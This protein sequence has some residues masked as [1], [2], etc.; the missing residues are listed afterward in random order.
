MTETHVIRI[1]NLEAT[2]TTPDGFAA[3]LTAALCARHGYSSTIVDP[4]TDTESPNPQTQEQFAADVVLKF[5]RDEVRAH[6]AQLA[7]QTAGAAA[8]AQMDAFRD[9]LAVSTTD[10]S[11]GEVP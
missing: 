11:E 7:E 3:M 10:L 4:D 5:C 9:Q 8:H 2:I 6:A 1:G